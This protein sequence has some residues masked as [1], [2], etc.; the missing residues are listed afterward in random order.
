MSNLYYVH[1]D[2]C[3]NGSIC[4]GYTKGFNQR[5][6]AHNTARWRQFIWINCPL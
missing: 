3:A 6:A 2:S 4:T 5:I 1:I